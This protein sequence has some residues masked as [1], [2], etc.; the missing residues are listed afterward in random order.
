MSQS[1]E[2]KIKKIKI[3]K[4]VLYSKGY[5]DEIM[6]IQADEIHFDLTDA[7]WINSSFIGILLWCRKKNITAIV[8]E[9]SYV[10]QCLDML[11]AQN[12]IKVIHE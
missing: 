5:A 10:E 4:M 7:D 6:D 9:D 11:Q 2:P 1:P 8:R 3:T 12:F